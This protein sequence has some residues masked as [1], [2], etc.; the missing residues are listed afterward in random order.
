MTL[1]SFLKSLKTTCTLADAGIVMLQMNEVM[2][3]VESCSFKDS[4]AGNDSGLPAVAALD[5]KALSVGKKL[6]RSRVCK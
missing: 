5:K 3:E 6:A 2:V 1:S 4:S